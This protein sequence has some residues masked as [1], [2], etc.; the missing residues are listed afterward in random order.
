MF[1][2]A[3]IGNGTPEQIEKWVERAFKSAILGTYAQVIL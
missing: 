1:L 2:P 3:L